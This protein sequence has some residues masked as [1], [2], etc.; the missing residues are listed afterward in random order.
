MTITANIKNGFLSLIA[1]WGL[2]RDLYFADVKGRI[3]EK[4]G[5]Y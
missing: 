3:L 1:E 4:L 2:V 5:N